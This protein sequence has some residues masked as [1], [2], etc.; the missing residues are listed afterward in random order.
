MDVSLV[1]P[2]YRSAST[3][4]RLLD[5]FAKQD[6]KGEAEIVFVLEPS[7]D[8]SEALLTS[9]LS[10]SIRLIANEE[11]LGPMACRMKG[12]EEA[13]GKY[14]GFL[15]ADDFLEPDFL[16][17]MHGALAKS[18]ADIVNCSFYLKGERGEIPY[19]FP[20]RNGILTRDEA[21]RKLLGDLSIRGFLWSKMFKKELLLEKPMLV[22]PKDHLFEDV[23]F[24]FSSFAKCR[25]VVT[26]KDPL[27]HY[28]K[29]GKTSVTSRQN[30]N[31]AQEHLDCFL[32]MRAYCEL[33]D[34]P[35][36]R[37][38]FFSSRLR[39]KIS[40]DFDLFK[41]KKAGLGKD[42]AKRILREF[43]YIYKEESKDIS[44]LSGSPI[45][46]RSLITD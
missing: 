12:I 4:P 33:L 1:C 23:A 13:K 11:R 45:V 24:C 30:P 18:E 9:R 15:D 34:D 26:L 46:K 3:L 42:E 22:L 35:K 32:A 20:G 8:L 36:L 44:S 38:A 25:S 40:L 10:S 43:S 27:Y 28:S 17:K 29:E 6:F 31:R 37:E 7:D 2:C 41:S 19:P 16:S 5:S 39:S 14:V 21:I